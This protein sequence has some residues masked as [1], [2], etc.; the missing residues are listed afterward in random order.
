M[1]T[2]FGFDTQPIIIGLI[3]FFQ[4]LLSPVA[5]VLDFL[6]NVLSRK[7]EFEVQTVCCAEHVLNDYQAD[8]FAKTLGYG[9]NLKSGLIKINIENLGN[10]NPDPWYSTYHYSHPP[11]LERLNALGV[12]KD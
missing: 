5:H 1:Y 10:L 9:E 4:F 11:L 12:K 2:S 8:R 3:V 6:M 7:F